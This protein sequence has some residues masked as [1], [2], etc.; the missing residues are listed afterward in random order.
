MVT[1]M[2]IFKHIFKFIMK[3]VKYI[4]ICEYSYN[5][6]SSLYIYTYIK[7]ENFKKHSQYVQKIVY[8]YVRS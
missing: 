5:H 2:N 6:I 3:N 8:R 7:N 1:D 4:S